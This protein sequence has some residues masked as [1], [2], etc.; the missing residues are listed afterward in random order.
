MFK[1]N[2][3]FFFLIKMN[4]KLVGFQCKVLKTELNFVLQNSKAS[5]FFNVLDLAEFMW[6][7]KFP[8]TTILAMF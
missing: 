4:R 7:S 2:L 5:K 1:H 3:F 6:D 8:H